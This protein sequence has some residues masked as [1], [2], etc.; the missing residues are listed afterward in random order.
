MT[1]A[2]MNATS[3]IATED[4]DRDLLKFIIANLSEAQKR[5]IAAKSEALRRSYINADAPGHDPWYA[6][7]LARCAA[8]ERRF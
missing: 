3:N 6:I 1:Y 8:I 7:Y 5:K 4:A 2:E